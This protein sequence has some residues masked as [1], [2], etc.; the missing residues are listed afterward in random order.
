MKWYSLDVHLNNLEQ[1]TK[2]IA[3]AFKAAYLS[4][5][6]KENDMALFSKRIGDSKTSTFY[7]TPNS[8][9]IAELFNA[10]PCDQPGKEDL[11]LI[12]GDE[13]VYKVFFG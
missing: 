4:N 2:D 7:F 5:H 9:N 10:T 3:E 12:V 11:G 1:S 8:K 13:V 6:G